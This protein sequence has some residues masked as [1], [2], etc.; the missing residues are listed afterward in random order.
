MSI[1]SLKFISR[2]PL[3][4]QSG[5]LPAALETQPIIILSLSCITPYL[6]WLSQ[7]IAIYLNYLYCYFDIIMMKCR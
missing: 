5:A 4:F 1:P 6:M 3:D 7:F 2:Y